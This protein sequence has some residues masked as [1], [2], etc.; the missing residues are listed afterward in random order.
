MFPAYVELFGEKLTFLNN[1]YFNYWSFLLKYHLHI[2][3]K[4]CATVNKF[5]LILKVTYTGTTYVYAC[6]GSCTDGTVTVSGTT[7]TFKCCA[8]DNCNN[9]STVTTTTTTTAKS[10]SIPLANNL[11][12]IV[13]SVMIP[14][15]IGVLKGNL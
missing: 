5:N 3:I 1:I 7:Y 4:N 11:I 14:S 2:F 15:C 13:I 6:S 10:G 9:P 12:L 8:T